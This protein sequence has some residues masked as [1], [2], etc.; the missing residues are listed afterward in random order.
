[1]KTRNFK[2]IALLLCLAMIATAVFGCAKKTDD[3]AATDA[4][5]AT[6][7]T[8][9]DATEEPAA[10]EEPVD[11]YVLKVGTLAG[12][13]GMG[14]AKLMN[15]CAEGGATAGKYAITLYSSPDAIRSALLSG[16]LDIAA[17]PVNLSAVIWAK[18]SGKYQIAA[19]NT[20]GV[21]YM[22]ENGSTVNSVSDLAG[23]TIYATG[24]GSTP[25]Y[26][27]NYI[28]EKNGITDATIEYKT[29][30][31][32]LATLMA[33]GEVVLGMLPEPMV[34]T[35]TTKNTDVRVALNLT[36]EW[37]KV[38][39]G[40]SVQGC[41]SVSTDIISNHKALLDTFLDDYKA[42]VEFVNNN[43][44]EAAEMIVAAGIVGAAPIAKKAIPRC[45]IVFIEGSEMKTILNQFYAVLY[46]ANAASVGG[47]MPT[48]ELYYVR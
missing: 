43:I 39:E 14:M 44:D 47:S 48:D 13:T 25:E 11:D 38:S 9:T 34:T 35:V 27:L 36:E 29:E 8:D 40:Q 12:P 15:D 31:S 10:T 23:K 17:L 20:L 32:E 28:L 26:I 42:S 16:E 41:I 18:T 3:A 6:E 7:A 19:V 21:L 45:N 37:A 30:H 1:M 46:A 22:L 4:P 5:V 2:L 33:A 24:Q